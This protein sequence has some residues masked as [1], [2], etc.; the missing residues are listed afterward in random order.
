MTK[1]FQTCLVKL[2]FIKHY[3]FDD[4]V[5][6]TRSMKGMTTVKVLTRVRNSDASNTFGNLQGLLEGSLGD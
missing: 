1:S 4:L 5:K 3:C 2:N 6:M